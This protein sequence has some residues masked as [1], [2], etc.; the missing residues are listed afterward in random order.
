MPKKNEKWRIC[1]DYRELKKNTLKDH[2]PLPF[3]D[4]VL[5]SLDGKKL[6]YFL[7]G[8]SGYSQIKIALEDQDKKKIQDFSNNHQMFLHI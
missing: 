4:Q 7:D 2:F 1:V 8:F 5:D 3:I 6:F